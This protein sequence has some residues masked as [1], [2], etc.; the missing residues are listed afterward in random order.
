MIPHM[1][2]LDEPY[3]TEKAKGDCDIEFPYEVPQNEYFLMG[4]HRITSIDSRSSV[5]GCSKSKSV[6]EMYVCH[7]RYS[8]QFFCSAE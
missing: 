4:D 7:Q 3:L 1:K 2:L 6:I 5:I 8:D